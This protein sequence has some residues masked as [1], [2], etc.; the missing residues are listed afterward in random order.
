[1][2]QR[3]PCTVDRSENN[4]SLSG[5]AWARLLVFLHSEDREI[6]P[7]YHF[8]HKRLLST[9]CAPSQRLFYVHMEIFSVSLGAGT[10]ERHPS[11]HTSVLLTFEPYEQLRFENKHKG[12]A[13]G[14]R[15]VVPDGSRD[16]HERNG[17]NTDRDADK[18]RRPRVKKDTRKPMF[19]KREFEVM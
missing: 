8:R 17:S 11:R 19:K 18:H 7:H 9:E 12:Y 13:P 6:F 4:R 1:M 15:K 3:S 14:R 5:Q 2:I 10:G 16:A